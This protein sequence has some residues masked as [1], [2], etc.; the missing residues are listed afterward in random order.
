MWVTR[1]SKRGVG[2]QERRTVYNRR[3]A[4]ACRRRLAIVASR[5]S[6]SL[7]SASVAARAASAAPDRTP[8]RLAR[9]I[10]DEILSARFDRRARAARARCPPAP[11]EA[12]Q[13][14]D[15]V[16]VVVADRARSREPRA[17]RAARGGGRAPRSTPPTRGPRASRSGPKRGSIWPAPTRRSCSGG[18]SAGERLAAARDG[19]RIRA[20]SNARSRSIRRCTTPSSASASTTTT[21]TSR[22]PAAKIL[23]WLLLLPGGD[24]AQG[25]REML[26][27][28]EHGRAA[29]RR[30][31]LSAALAVSLVRAPAASARSSCCAASTQRYPSNPVFLQRIAEV[32]GE[33]FHDHPASAAAWQLLLDRARRADERRRLAAV[34]RALG[35]ASDD[36]R[37]DR[38]IEHSPDRSSATAPAAPDDGLARAHLLLGAAYDRLGSA[39]LAVAAY[40]EALGGAPPRCDDIRSRA[41]A[42]LG[43][44]RT[45]TSRRRIGCRSKDC[46]RSSAAT[47]TAVS[48][49]G[50]RRALT[51]DD[52]VIGYRYSRAL[53]RDRRRDA[54][55]IDARTRACRRGRVPGDRPGVGVRRCAAISERTAI[56][57]AIA[58]YQRALGVVGGALAR[59]STPQLR[60]KRLDPRN[61]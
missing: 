2:H 53:Q 18:S 17:R 22:R 8:R 40:R 12:C 37:T 25:L 47:A 24:R 16:G 46:A 56:E 29:A 15:G 11:R 41:R 55:A 54:R 48:L 52:P 59:A 14:L 4:D 3:H 10:Y 27:A 58:Y 13:A 33:Y 35:L 61:F 43:R 30:S 6:S 51:P 21:P 57:R 50:A 49:A 23:R 34:T 31:R 38:A 45:P 7:P 19:N 42:A 5:C 28:R 1:K 9:A 20:R 36:V 26:E 44:D 32:Q 39:T 60:L